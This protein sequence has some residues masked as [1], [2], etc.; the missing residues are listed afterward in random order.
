MGG[1]GLIL[2]F[3]IIVIAA[4]V[5]F[6]GWLAGWWLR[7][8]IEDSRHPSDYDEDRGPRPTH[9]AVEDPGHDVTFTSREDV[10]PS[11]A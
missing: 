6:V 7:P 5:G 4:G 8:E 11:H 2:L 3:F 9:V 10:P 1:I